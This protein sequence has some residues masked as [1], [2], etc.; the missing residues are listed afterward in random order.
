MSADLSDST[1]R[2]SVLHHGAPESA[3]D[4]TLDT[5]NALIRLAARG[6]SVLDLA[7]ELGRPVPE[8]ARRLASEARELAASMPDRDAERVVERLHLDALRAA[9]LPG[10]LSG[11]ETCV[12]LCIRIHQARAAMLGLT[13]GE[14]TPDEGVSDL[15]AIR[16]R[17]DARRAATD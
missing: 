12:R 7:H 5:S 6:L 8:V 4:R 9:L 2:P 1:P 3:S 13:R 14:T 15:D 17:R 10:A 11:D 16:A